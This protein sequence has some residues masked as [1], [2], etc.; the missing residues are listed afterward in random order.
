[1]SINYTSTVAIKVEYQGREG[2]KQAQRDFDGLNRTLSGM[3][4]GLGAVKGALG[5]L[6]AAFTVKEVLAFGKSIVDLGDNMNDL[7]QKSGI[8]VQTLSDLKAAAEDNGMSFDSFEVSLKKFSVTLAKAQAG[9]AEAQSGFKAL[10]LS[11]RNEDGS[12]KKT[13]QLLLEVADKFKNVEDGSAK[14]AVAVALAGKSGA[15]LIPLLNGGREAIEGMGVQMSDNFVKESAKFNDELGRMKRNTQQFGVALAESLLPPLN[16]AIEK[17]NQWTQSIVRNRPFMQNLATAMRAA[18]G[19]QFL[20]SPTALFDSQEAAAAKGQPGKAAGSPSS[21]PKKSGTI[22]TRF[23]R[24]NAQG[25]NQAQKEANALE[26]LRAEGEKDLALRKLEIDALFMT[27]AEREKASIKIKDEAEAKKAVIGFTKAGAKAY[28]EMNQKIIEQKQA[29]VDL[30]N[31]QRRS[32]GAGA[33][34]ALV[35]YSESIRDVAKQSKELFLRAFQGMED[36][37]VNFVQTGKLSFADLA[38]Q[39]EADL[40]RIA[41]RQT[42]MRGIMSGLGAA[43]GGGA[44]FADGGVM[45]GSGPMPLKKYATGGIARS[46]QLALFGE[47]SQPEAFVPLP[48]GRSIPVTMQGGGSG[49]TNV[50]VN[51]HVSSAGASSQSERSDSSRGAELGKAISAAV[52]AE[53]IKQRRPGGLLT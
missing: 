36:A 32:F 17:F 14:A 25:E 13:D 29:L 48:D 6:A 42:I 7:R 11:L 20:G 44:A 28:L 30:E 26:K 27:S 45:T 23:L 16:R 40:I 15:D 38:R 22:D 3:P 47:G 43:F 10:G 1:V 24:S 41:I 46:P 18:I 35:E 19:Q 51:V 8:G 2:A 50:E 34:Q 39:I 4:R 31:Q 37:L 52:T 12:L 53:L 33:K 9:S 5:A 21:P 49:G